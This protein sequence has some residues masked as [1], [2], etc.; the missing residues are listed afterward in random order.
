M[1]EEWKIRRFRE[2]RRLKEKLELE[3]AGFGSLRLYCDHG[4]RGKTL[5]R[6]VL[7]T[8]ELRAT[9]RALST[10]K[11]GLYFTKF[12]ET[13]KYTFID[14]PT[15]GLALYGLQFWRKYTAGRRLRP[16][17]MDYITKRR[18]K[19]SKRGHF[20]AWFEAARSTIAAN[21]I[22]RNSRSLRAL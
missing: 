12:V 16:L 15:R 11:R 6:R 7:Y 2:Y 8:Q 17:R 22:E 10:W 1:H 13:L 14:E 19:A 18:D 21:V 5:L 4:Q 20:A 9:G 3:R